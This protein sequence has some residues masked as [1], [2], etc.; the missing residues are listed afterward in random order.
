[1]AWVV[2][3]SPSLLHLND[4]VRTVTSS[5]RAGA[6]TCRWLPSSDRLVPAVQPTLGSDSIT[7]ASGP[8]R[9]VKAACL[10]S[11]LLLAEI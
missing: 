9:K 11:V 6:Y 5:L 8:L 10:T 4:H 2:Y 3:D 7:E 1:M